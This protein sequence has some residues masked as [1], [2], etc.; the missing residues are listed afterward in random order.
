VSLLFFVFSSSF[1]QVVE[2]TWFTLNVALTAGLV[3]QLLAVQVPA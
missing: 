3:H 1:P 2:L